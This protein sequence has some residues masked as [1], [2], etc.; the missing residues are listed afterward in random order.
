M[1]PRK[2][3]ELESGANYVVTRTP[4][5][6]PDGFVLRNSFPG[7]ATTYLYRRPGACD[8]QHLSQRLA[9]PNWFGD[10]ESTDE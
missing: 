5:E 2:F 7:P 8:A 10:R 3:S 6:Q 9:S 4:I 1:S